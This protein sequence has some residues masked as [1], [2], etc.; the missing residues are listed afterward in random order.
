MADILTDRIVQK[1]SKL[2]DP[3]L[4]SPENFSVELG[5]S[6]ADG[7]AAAIGAHL[8]M[9]QHGAFDKLL[10]KYVMKH[11]RQSESALNL[12]GLFLESGMKDCANFVKA[13]LEKF[14]IPVPSDAETL[15]E[16]PVSLPNPPCGTPD[17]GA[18]AVGGSKTGAKTKIACKDPAYKPDDGTDEKMET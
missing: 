9:N 2:I 17:E 16:T 18:E 11:G 4:L 1:L 14:N 12:R 13:E 5:F 3:G 8:T 6:K 15:V 10:S 7:N